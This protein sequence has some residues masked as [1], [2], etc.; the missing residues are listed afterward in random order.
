MPGLRDKGIALNIAEN[1]PAVVAEMAVG[2]ERGARDIRIAIR[3]NIEDAI[4]NIIIANRNMSI[5]AINVKAEDGKIICE[6]A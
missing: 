6:K 1:V 5:D 4:A 3:K 2:G